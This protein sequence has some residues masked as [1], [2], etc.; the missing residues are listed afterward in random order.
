MIYIKRFQKTQLGLVEA[1]TDNANF[2]GISDKKPLK[3]S[4][5]N[6]VAT[7]EVTTEGT[8]GAAA[9]GNGA[10]TFS[11]TTFSIMAL[12]ILGLFT[13]ISVLMLSVACFYFY[14]ECYYGEC[15]FAE[16]RGA[17]ITMYNTAGVAL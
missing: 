12:R 10:T 1:F 15:C 11:I 5:I 4:A 8:V 2:A 14:T 17:P 13:T 7:V 3:V 16:C 9:S 6:H